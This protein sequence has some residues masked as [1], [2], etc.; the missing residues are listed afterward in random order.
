MSESSGAATARIRAVGVDIPAALK[1]IDARAVGSLPE[2]LEVRRALDVLPILGTVA[3]EAH[4]EPSDAPTDGVESDEE[5]RLRV[6]RRVLER[7]ARTGKWMPAR[8]E[9]RSTGRGLGGRTSASPSAR[10]TS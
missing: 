4:H 8:T 7:L 6:V 1:A 10:C 2:V 5:R 3:P 9:K